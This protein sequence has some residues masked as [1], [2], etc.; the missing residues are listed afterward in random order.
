MELVDESVK[1]LDLP[2]TAGSAT[3]CQMNCIVTSGFP[4]ELVQSELMSSM[5]SKWGILKK[6]KT[7][8]SIFKITIVHCFSYW[9]MVRTM[10]PRKRK[11][12]SKDLA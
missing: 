7:F 10:S 4:V 9:S 12:G 8:W 11:C 1:S 5:E 3:V 2:T 6:V